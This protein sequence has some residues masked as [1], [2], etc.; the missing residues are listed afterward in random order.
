MR[1]RTNSCILHYEKRI[2]CDNFVSLFQIEAQVHLH[3]FK[4]QIN[5][6]GQRKMDVTGITKDW[7]GC[8]ELCYCCLTM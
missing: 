4:G 3:F 2:A 5:Q 8:R 1:V 7:S 6:T